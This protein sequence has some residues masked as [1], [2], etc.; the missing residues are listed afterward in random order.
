M[1]KAPSG[2]R[3]TEMLRILCFASDN[4][5]K[6]DISEIDDSHAKIIDMDRFL[7]NLAG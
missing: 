7:S 6:R 3:E 4:E 1:R 2:S 5:G